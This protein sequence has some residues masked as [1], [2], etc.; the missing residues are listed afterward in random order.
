[1]TDLIVAPKYNNK[2]EDAFQNYY[3]LHEY[4]K[5]SNILLLSSFIFITNVTTAFINELYLYSGLFAILTITSL[6]VHYTKTEIL[7]NIIDKIAVLLVVLCGAFTF[8][9]KITIKKWLNCLIIVITF[10][11]CI[12]LYIYGFFFK[13]YCF[14]PDNYETYKYH[15]L[16]HIIGSIG[17]HFIIF[18]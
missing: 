10:L 13:K 11:V 3:K 15:V 8:H 6:F 14:C 18:L 7:P 4:L 1:M 5:N 16:M 12:H 17:H 2:E 9:K